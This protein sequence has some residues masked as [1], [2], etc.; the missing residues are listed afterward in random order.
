MCDLCTTNESERTAALNE[1]RHIADELEEMAR[2]Y[3]EI[4][5]GERKPHTNAMDIPTIRAASVIR[6]LVRDWV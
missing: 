2:F 6:H 3:R 5:S 4:A 1:N